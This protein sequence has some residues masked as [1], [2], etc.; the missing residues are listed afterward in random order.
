MTDQ[1][2]QDEN[3][4]QQGQEPDPNEVFQNNVSQELEELRAWRAE[5]EEEKQTAQETQQLD[6]MLSDMHTKYGE[7]DNNWILLRISEHGDPD[8]AIKE[9]NSM[10]GKYSQSGPSRQAPKV[11]GG[12][13]GVPSDQIKTQEL[14]GKD[15]RHAVANMLQGI[16]E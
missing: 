11:M 1:Y 13:G 6:K 4:Q 9:W 7:F 8:K 2:Q 15:R 5:Q 3:E 14:R 16:G 10:V 12:Q